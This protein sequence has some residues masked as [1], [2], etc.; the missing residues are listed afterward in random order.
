MLGLRV[1][2]NNFHEGSVQIGHTDK[3]VEELH[4]F[5]DEIL[6]ENCLKEKTAERLRGRVNFFEGHCFGRGPAQ[7]LKTLRSQARSGASSTCLNDA[8][9]RCIELLR[10]RLGA[11]IPLQISKK[12]LRSCFLLTDRACEPEKAFGGVGAVLYN[13]EGSAVAAFSERVPQLILERLLSCSQNPI[14]ELE[15]LPILLTFRKWESLLT[16]CQIVCYLDNDAAR[17]ALVKSCAGTQEAEDIVAGVRETLRTE[18]SFGCGTQGYL[19]LA[20]RQ[21]GRAGLG[22]RVSK[23]HKQGPGYSAEQCGPRPA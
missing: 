14:Y 3:R 10:R 21:M 16:S 17:H 7:A 18:R 11:T 20:T 19:P 2:L 1:D 6:T 13:S 9:Q 4:F 23:G 8:A 5:L 12:S 22:G 15:L